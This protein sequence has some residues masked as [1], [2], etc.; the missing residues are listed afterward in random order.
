MVL[1]VINRATL[2]ISYDIWRTLL[3]GNKAFTSARIEHLANRLGLRASVD[4]LVAAYRGAERHFNRYA[5]D[6]GRDGGMAER[7]GLMYQLL[8]LDPATLPESSVLDAI[9]RE[10]GELHCHPEYMPSLLEPDLLHWLDQ[11]AQLGLTQV[12]LSNTG[13]DSGPVM[14]PVLT[15][16]GIMSRMEFAMFSAEEGLAKPNPALFM[17]M[18]RQLNVPPAQIVH[19]GDNPTADYA[20]A[21]SAGL[22]AIL[23][24]AQPSQVASVARTSQLLAVLR[25]TRLIVTSGC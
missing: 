21:T 1:P 11:I 12:L 6:T 3:K 7:L 15:K 19:V 17:R 16:L 24:A 18:S 10:L 5:I 22:Q 8:G 13:M 9:Q 23:Y 14:R 20:G 25:R 2:A 4:E